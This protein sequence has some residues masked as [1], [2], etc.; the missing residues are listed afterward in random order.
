MKAHRIAGAVLCA[1]LPFGCRSTDDS[2]GD[3]MLAEIVA[4]CARD[5]PAVVRASA[6]LLPPENIDFRG[7]QDFGSLGDKPRGSP[8]CEVIDL[9]RALALAGIENPTIALAREAIQAGRALQLQ[10]DALLLP[11]LDAGASFNWHRGTLQSSTGIIRDLERRSAYV[12]G[13]AAAIGAGTVGFP[14]VRVSAH[15]GDALFEPQATR[16]YV[17][18]RQLDAQAT[19]NAVLLA[20]ALRYLELAGAEAELKALQSS[21]QDFGAIAQL[22]RNF[23]K[24]GRGREADAQRARTEALLVEAMAQRAEEAIAVAS[25]ELARLLNVDPSV[26]LQTPSMSVPSLQLVDPGEPL[27]V[28]LQTALLNRPELAARSADVAVVETRLR[29]ERVRPLL[30]V[31][32]VGFSAGGFGGGSNQAT[33]NFGPLQGRT[34]FDV[35]AFWTLQNFGF[36]N[37]AVQRQLQA[38]LGKA[39]FERTRVIDLIRT[40]VAEAYT[41]VSA[42]RNEIEVARRRLEKSRQAYQQDLTRARNLEGRPIEVLD[43]ARL[44]QTARHEWVRAAIGYSQAQIRLFVA[45]GQP[46]ALAV[47]DAPVGRP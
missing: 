44:L 13:G 24:T 17:V 15:L 22:T 2:P 20:V 10:A 45:M 39:V 30:P 5:T 4:G 37:L 32:S 28:L 33:T 21:E 31:L 23:A 40:E 16:Q 1:L 35:S 26:R 36:G 14:G 25:A 43:S 38:E 6:R 34:D 29:K 8:E 11:T 3:R 19:Q 42:R 7:L 47:P 18:A 46:P 12:G 9:E 27:E 41:E